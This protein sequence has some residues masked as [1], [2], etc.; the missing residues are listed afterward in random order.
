MVNDE[1]VPL[2]WVTRNGQRIKDSLP[3]DEPTGRQVIALL[4]NDR[5]GMFRQARADYDLELF[6]VVVPTTE[7]LKVAA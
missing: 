6:A 1:L 4:E 7:L 5:D 2:Y 3:V